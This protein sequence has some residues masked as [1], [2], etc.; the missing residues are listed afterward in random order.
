MHK[1]DKS[2]SAWQLVQQALKTQPIVSQ[3]LAGQLDLYFER[4]IC[5]PMRFKVPPLPGILLG[6][7]FGGTKIVGKTVDE[8]FKADFFTGFSVLIPPYCATRWNF[9]G[10]TD[11]ALFYLPLNSLQTNNRAIEHHLSGLTRPV[12]VTEPLSSMVIQQVAQELFSPRS[13]DDFV[14]HL[15][16]IALEK[17]NRELAQNCALDIKPNYLAL[18]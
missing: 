2:S 7:Q 16:M 5:Q 17:V 1:K 18:L 15:T 10:V 6:T 12:E 11:L 3:P 13:N 8:H 4:Y 9:G 14:E